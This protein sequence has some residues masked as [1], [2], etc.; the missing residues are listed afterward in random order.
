MNHDLFIGFAFVGMVVAFVMVAA[1]IGH[2]VHKSQISNPVKQGHESSA[3]QT[4]QRLFE[5]I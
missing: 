1:R 3:V 4:A 2:A 5:N